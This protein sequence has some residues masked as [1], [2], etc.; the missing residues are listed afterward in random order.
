[1]TLEQVP[2]KHKKGAEKSKDGDGK[3]S[4]GTFSTV[5]RN[6]VSV[7]GKF[8]FVPAS[9]GNVGVGII[10]IIKGIVKVPG[11]GG[12]DEGDT[13]VGSRKVR[14]SKVAKL[15]RIYQDI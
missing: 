15:N 6:F 1:M 7:I 12:M 3:D 14:E 8:G 5:G 10:L 11:V 9:T 4:S 13:L 2:E